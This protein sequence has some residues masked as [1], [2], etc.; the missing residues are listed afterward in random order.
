[1]TLPLTEYTA[2]PGVAQLTYGYPAVELLPAAALAHAAGSLVERHGPAALLYGFMQGPGPL[3]EWVAVHLSST[4]GIDVEPAQVL[5]SGGASQALDQICSLLTDPRDVVLVPVP[6]YHLAVSI[7]REHPLVLLPVDA[8]GDDGALNIDALDDARNVARRNGL[9]VRML[10][11]IP[12]FANPSG[13]TLTLADRQALVAWAEQTGVLLVEDDVYRELCYEGSAPPSLWSMARPGAVLRLG[14]FS[15]TVAPGLRLGWLLADAPTIERFV[16]SGLYDS[17]GGT[18][19]FAALALETFLAQA[20][21]AAHLARARQGYRLRRDALL[22]A[23]E[24]HMPPGCSWSRPQGG[25]F[26]WLRLPEGIDSAAL[27]PLAQRHGVTYVPGSRFGLGLGFGEHLRLSF[28]FLSP[29][30][31]ADGARRLGAAIAEHRR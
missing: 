12:T 21:Y 2:M 19:H 10:Y 9:R 30:E 11:S 1:M 18:A 25:Y 13:A 16:R 29:A 31:L 5:I 28:S 7:L 3:L 20:D 14:S 22:A 8:T 4:E 6:T 24:Q 26:V 17:G 27:Q 15:K 23:L